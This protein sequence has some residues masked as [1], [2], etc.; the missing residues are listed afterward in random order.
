MPSTDQIKEFVIA[1]HGNLEEV[2]TMLEAD[3]DL[4]E[5]KHPWNETDFESALQAASH[6]GNAAIA[7]YLL[8]KGA[9]L[10]ITTSAMLGDLPAIKRF[11]DSDSSLIQATGGHGISLLTHG[12]I[13]GDPEIV[14]FLTSQG[15]T[16]GA[17]MALN[18][19]IEVDDLKIIKMLLERTEPDLT[20]K[21]VKGKTA[22]EIARENKQDA[23]VALLER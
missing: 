9:N 10:E 2:K 13:S 8:E 22:L 7:V 21:N 12:V 5:V 14:D 23:I 16:A 20:W 11:L 18:I 19:A 3:S 15:A 17:S 4:L 1:G 6:V